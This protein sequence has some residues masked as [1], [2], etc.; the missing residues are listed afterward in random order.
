MPE[1]LNEQLTLLETHLLKLIKQCNILF[2]ICLC[3]MILKL[4]KYF[5]KGL[6]MRL[7]LGKPDK[8][9]TVPLHYVV[10][11]NNVLLIWNC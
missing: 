10:N 5:V 7:V 4:G 1:K 8:V 3:S 6:K 2:C 9:Y 11:P